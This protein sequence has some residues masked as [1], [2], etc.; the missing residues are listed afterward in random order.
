MGYY[1]AIRI[2]SR[3]LVCV[4]AASAMLALGLV[5][6]G[7]AG[8]AQ[9]AG[10]DGEGPIRLAGADRY[11]TSAVIA[12]KNFTETGK[13]VFLATGADFP[14][15]LSAGPAAGQ[16]KSPVI[17]TAPTGLSASAAAELNRLR[18]A[19]VYVMGGSSV[20]SNAVLAAAKAYSPNVVRISGNDRYA[21]A[22]KTSQRFWATSGTA[23]IASGSSYADALSGGALAAKNGA[24]ILLTNPS[25]LVDPT[26]AELRRL[27][28]SKVVI[29]G[30][31]GAVSEKVAAQIR[32]AVP[33]V[34]VSRVQGADRFATAAAAAKA[35]WPNSDK[36]M[37]AVAWNF[38]DALAG[39]AAAA[40]NDAPLLLTNA[41]CMPR[42]VWDE[43][44]RL[45]V[46]TMGILGG[47]GVLTITSVSASCDEAGPW[48]AAS[49]TAR[50][51]SG[52]GD[53]VIKI[54]K[55]DGAKSIGMATMTHRGTG[56]F[57]VDGL[58]S[59]NNATGTLRGWTGG[60]YTGTVLFDPTPDKGT[61]TQLSI[62]ASGPWTISIASVTAAPTYG[63]THITG[64]Y[65]AVFNYSG[66][67]GTA[68]LSYQG[69]DNL[70]IVTMKKVA[71]R[72]DWGYLII[73]EPG[74]YNGSKPWPPGPAVVAAY[75]NAP[76]SLTIR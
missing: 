31:A 17:L 20:V 29:L 6:H 68:Q 38:P 3:R 34:S 2:A 48:P 53:A 58:D 11:S 66:T 25:V 13:S 7:P 16:K 27:G 69:L 36:A 1:V 46:M 62:T 19:N 30:G 49:A 9:A 41:S 35:G 63:K 60:D 4:L 24:P 18:P 42:S 33:G 44:A 43:S 61:T 56:D 21:T 10:L 39:V 51:Y 55:P 71:G 5:A 74:P 15:A 40:A 23:Y 32:A 28:P 52:V 57:I 76:W 70:T 47:E 14:D 54:S 50:S 73:D 45:G 26:K 64:R 65:D 37:Y 67:S 12:Q 59:N 72:W 8:Q 75:S 22:A